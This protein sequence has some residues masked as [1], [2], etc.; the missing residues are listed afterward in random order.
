M[1]KKKKNNYPYYVTIR[2]GDEEKKHL[3]NVMKTYSIRD[4]SKAYREAMK[5]YSLRA[6]IDLAWKAEK[7]KKN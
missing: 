6:T 2:F 5:F 3:D 7:D 4:K 1:R